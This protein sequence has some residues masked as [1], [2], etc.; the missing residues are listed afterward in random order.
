MPRVSVVIPTYNRA[1]YLGEAVES[2]MAQTYT[3]WELI[4]V[5]DGSVDDTAAVLAGYGGRVTT[6]RQPHVGASAARNAG[7][8]VARGELI[9]FLDSD[10]L[11]LPHNLEVLVARLDQR[12]EAAVAYGWYV[13]AN[14]AGQPTARSGPKLPDQPPFVAGPGASF[15]PCGMNVEGDVLRPMLLEESMLLGT[16][17]LRREAALTVGG[18]NRRRAYQEHWEFF[19]RL[20]RAGFAFVCCRST[21]ALVRLHTDNRSSNLHQMLAD[22]L[23]VL[24]ECFEAPGSAH[25]PAGLRDHALHAAY[26]EFARLFYE[27]GQAE[28]GARCLQSALRLGRLRASDEAKLT[29]LISHAAL[30][31]PSPT[32]LADVNRSLEAL[33]DSAEAAAFRRRVLY[34]VCRAL[35]TRQRLTAPVSVLAWWRL[36]DCVDYD[37]QLW[38]HSL[39]KAF[40]PHR[41]RQTR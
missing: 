31:E 39:L 16:A 40:V 32:A 3:D 35:A 4:V 38:L 23:A 27:T 13:W 22:R 29:W 20:A 10:D 25:L 36:L 33:S 7:L 9:S 15:T 5:D 6:V 34:R 18:F 12:P 14:E 17:L 41:A 30:S 37:W 11:F 1:R 28:A 8:A 19:L 26:A 24:E 21:V 2:V